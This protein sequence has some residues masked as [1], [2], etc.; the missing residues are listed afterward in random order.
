METQL[1]A[2]FRLTSFSWS[3]V[4]VYYFYTVGVSGS[5]FYSEHSVLCTLCTGVQR[6]PSVVLTDRKSVV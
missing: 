4:C 2:M 5:M 1:V 6:I 3:V